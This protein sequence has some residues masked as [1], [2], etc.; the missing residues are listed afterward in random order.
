MMQFA[1]TS[2]SKSEKP[3]NRCLSCG[4]SQNMGRRKYCSPECRQRLKR[5]LTMRT[6]LL[7]A[8]N[9]RYATFYFTDSTLVLDVLTHHSETLFSFF[10]PRTGNATPADEFSHMANLLG[11]AWWAEKRRTQKRYLASR[12]LLECARKNHVSCESVKPLT[13]RHPTH[14]NKSITYLK[15]DPSDLNDPDLKQKIKAAYRR[16]AKK[17]HPDSGGF[18]ALFRKIHQA[19]MD[20]VKWSEHP[21]FMNRR[22]FPD[23][24]FY[25]GEA[26]RWV[27]P[28]A[29]RNGNPTP[30]TGNDYS[31]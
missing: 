25:D 29:I 23:K 21:T 19:Y 12:H 9:T 5:I 3:K 10:Y 28:T 13:T 15:L 31:Q 4:T 27:Q 11:N 17:H 6:G 24:W 26:D 1:I 30:G 7:R 2:L 22:G 18:A 14:I 20:L 8:L 16:Q